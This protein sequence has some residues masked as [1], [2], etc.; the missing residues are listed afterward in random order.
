MYLDLS[1]CNFR[2]N[3]GLCISGSP[4]NISM[5]F[6]TPLVHPD[7]PLVRLNRLPD[8][9]F[10]AVTTEKEYH[11]EDLVEWRN[12]R[13]KWS[14]Y[15][16]EI[17]L[18]DMNSYKFFINS[19]LTRF[20]Y[21]ICYLNSFFFYD[22]QRMFW[23]VFDGRISNRLYLICN[24]FF[25]NIITYHFIVIFL[26]VGRNILYFLCL[27]SKYNDFARSSSKVSC[28][29]FFPFRRS[30]VK[31]HLC[32]CPGNSSESTWNGIETRNINLWLL[33]KMR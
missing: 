32:F 18:L 20:Y 31:S 12:Y 11:W 6:L 2:S 1:S 27:P 15:I 4:I 21:K 8:I 26:V 14:M 9:R 25:D 33:P 10:D 22:L 24:L 23:K 19:V 16:L 13:N 5:I 28:A 3:W 7:T 17:A 29:L 30:W